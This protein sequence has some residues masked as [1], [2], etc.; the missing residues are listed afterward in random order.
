MRRKPIEEP[1][2][3]KKP[4][5]EPIIDDLSDSEIGEASDNEKD[6][7]RAPKS[8]TTGKRT[9]RAAVKRPAKKKKIP[10]ADPGTITETLAE[11]ADRE[12]DHAY[13][14]FVEAVKLPVQK[15]EGPEN[16]VKVVAP[17]YVPVIRFK[18]AGK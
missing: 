7:A 9:R 1:A 16:P 12:S 2:D 18:K 15:P 8:T 10:G 11:D 5:A 6:P 17:S 3:L 4:S 13:E 14:G